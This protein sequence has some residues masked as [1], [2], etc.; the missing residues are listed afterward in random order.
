MLHHWVWM[1]TETVS[2]TPK[3][4]LEMSNPVNLTPSIRSKLNFHPRQIWARLTTASATCRT[5]KTEVTSIF[6]VC[7]PS[8]LARTQCKRLVDFSAHDQPKA[9]PSFAGFWLSRPECSL[10]HW[11]SFLFFCR[12]CE[13]TGPFA[14]HNTA[15]VRAERRWFV[16]CIGCSRPQ[17]TSTVYRSYSRLLSSLDPCKII[18]I[19]LGYI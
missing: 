5:R 9:P 18:E 1:N 19:W 17:F 15:I 8:F 2:S 14:L 7:T 16:H 12:L 10:L 3:T 4:G 11:L 13:V 6:S